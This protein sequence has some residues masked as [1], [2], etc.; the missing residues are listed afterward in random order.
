MLGTFKFL[1][2]IAAA[3]ALAF[4]S[5]LPD[6]QQIENRMVRKVRK[7]SNNK[8]FHDAYFSSSYISKEGAR[9][10]KD[11]HALYA[12]QSKEL[13]SLSNTQLKKLGLI[14]PKGKRLSPNPTKFHIQYNNLALIAKHPIREREL[15][16]LSN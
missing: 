11:R 9:R 5:H 6:I 2:V 14:H 15:K 3:N 10:I 12:A 7:G 8:L 13:Q 4:T 1:E 16:T